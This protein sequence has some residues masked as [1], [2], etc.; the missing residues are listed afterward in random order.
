MDRLE[1]SDYQWVRH[2]RYLREKMGLSQRELGDL[3]GV[4]GQTVYRWE[5]GK[6]LPSLKFRSSILQMLA[7]ESR[8]LEGPFDFRV[9]RKAAVVE[10]PADGRIAHVTQERTLVANQK[11][12]QYLWEYYSDGRIAILECTPGSIAGEHHRGLRTYT[13]QDLARDLKPGDE[14]EV[15]LK[16]EARDTFTSDTEWH[17]LE[18][19]EPID[20]LS[21]R[22]R[23]SSLRRPSSYTA[24]I[25]DGLK[26]SGETDRIVQ[27]ELGEWYELSWDAKDP[28]LF[29]SYTLRWKW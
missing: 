17:S 13:V 2:I 24:D 25:V 27:R 28:P 16:M 22:V 5:C 10:I 18:V 7:A 11:V 3:F 8:R 23:F 4:S 12:R 21:M 9:L 6:T 26:T 1:P 19:S 15:T 14:V 20:N 29:A